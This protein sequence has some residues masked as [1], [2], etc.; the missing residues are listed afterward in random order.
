MVYL[1]KIYF[2]TGDNKNSNW[3]YVWHMADDAKAKH[4]FQVLK[5]LVKRYNQ[6]L[7][8]PS[9]SKDFSRDHYN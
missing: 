5:G 4:V 1:L 3:R 7:C 8:I 2:I 6:E 9:I